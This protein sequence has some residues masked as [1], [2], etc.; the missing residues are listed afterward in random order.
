M[1]S[2]KHAFD[3]R[4]AKQLAIVSGCRSRLVEFAFALEKR[5]G[6]SCGFLG[7]TIRGKCVAEA[8]ASAQ[9]IAENKGLPEFRQVSLTPLNAMI[10]AEEGGAQPQTG[11]VVT[12]AAAGGY[13]RRKPFHLDFEQ[14]DE[15]TRTNA[16][17]YFSVLKQQHPSVRMVELPGAVVTGQGAVV[18]NGEK[19]VKESV[20]E[21]TAQ[22]LPPDGFMASDGGY[23]MKR[24]L[25]ARIAAPCVLAK[26]PWYRNYG[27]WLVDGATVLALTAERIQ[28]ERLKVVVGQFGSPRMRAVVMDTIAQLVPG[29]TVLEHPDEQIWQ[30]DQLNYV[31]PPHV[32][33]LFKHPEALRRVRAGFLGA[34]SGMAPRRRLFIT[35]RTAGNRRLVN[36]AEIFDLC[37]ARG[38]QFVDPE[39]LSLREQAVLFSEAAA[40]IGAKGAA[41]TNCLF[42][43]PGTKVMLLSPAD[44]PDP[45]FWDV[46]PSCEYGEV[47]GPTLTAK[48]RGLNEFT[49]APQRV[50]AMLDAAGF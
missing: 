20:V 34:G 6:D 26:R 42:C 32:P 21:F 24:R 33:P 16:A 13:D 19:L 25:D 4:Q 2:P 45:F 17:Q 46:A 39:K 37:G 8:P 18:T 12:L 22:G 41:M 5:E 15:F 44:F 11:N 14:A 9:F 27:H 10:N 29:A 35:R 7:R 36:E 47:F 30:F 38:F 23:S 40:V 43:A 50:A 28:A 3:R 31:S 49:V 48:A 1:L